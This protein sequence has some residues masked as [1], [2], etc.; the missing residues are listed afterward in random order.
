MF[1]SCFGLPIGP[2]PTFSTSWVVFGTRLSPESALTHWLI[3]AVFADE[4]CQKRL[5]FGTLLRARR[6]VYSEICGAPLR[7][8]IERHYIW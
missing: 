3:Y 5:E 8:F 2:T 6:Q 4:V 7:M 1:W